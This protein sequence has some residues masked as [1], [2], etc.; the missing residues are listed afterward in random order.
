MAACKPFAASSGEA[1]YLA[2]NRAVTTWLWH[3]A[4]PTESNASTAS[5]ADIATYLLSSNVRCWTAGQRRAPP[6][7][8]FLFLEEAF[9]N[10]TI[11]CQNYRIKCF[12]RSL[13]R[14]NIDLQFR[15]RQ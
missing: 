8:N 2:C 12:D 4:S 5:C 14:F 1:P 11:I 6:G 15:H 3:I 7:C 10:P 9:V 13:A